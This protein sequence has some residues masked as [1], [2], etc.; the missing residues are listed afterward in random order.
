MMAVIERDL[1][2][3]QSVRSQGVPVPSFGQL[4]LLAG[5]CAAGWWGWTEYVWSRTR[6]QLWNADASFEA[7]NRAIE[8]WV[9]GGAAAIPD[10]VRGLTADDF[11]IRCAAARALGGIGAAA[12]SAAPALR[13]ASKDAHL[14]VRK[15]AIRALAQIAPDDPET[16]DMLMAVARD[17]DPAVREVVGEVIGPLREMALNPL[18]ALLADSQPVIRLEVIQLAHH[19]APDSVEVI[20]ALRRL[21]RD[22]DPS[23]RDY[24]LV[25]LLRNHR[26]SP[27]EILSWIEETNPEVVSQSLVSLAQFGPD[28]V[29]AVPELIRC[30]GRTDLRSTQRYP[31]VIEQALVWLKS[32]GTAAR[33]AIPALVRLLESREGAYNGPL[34]LATL[35]AAGADRDTLVPILVPALADS[36]LCN[37]AGYFLAKVDDDEARRQIPMLIE[38]SHSPDHEISNT[39][40]CAL[41]GLYPVAMTDVSTLTSHLSQESES[42]A[43]WA[44]MALARIGPGAASAVPEIVS[45][46]QRRGSRSHLAPLLIQA[47]GS[48]GPAAAPVTPLLMAVIA[49][50][51]HD[52][53]VRGWALVALARIGSTPPDFVTTL[54]SALGEESPD[55][56]SAALQ[57]LAALHP[58]DA[59]LLPEILRSLS[60]SRAEIRCAAAW[61]IADIVGCRAEVVTALTSHLRDPDARVRWVAAKALGRLGPPAFAA[62][63][64]LRSVRPVKEFP[65]K[66]SYSPPFA[67]LIETDSESRKREQSIAEV[68]LDA[69]RQI[70]P[71]GATAVESP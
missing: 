71:D 55:L 1:P 7:R 60:S 38:K 70:A 34:I 24:A 63:P 39:A 36:H 14:Q 21:E 33:P 6:S 35:A 29:M 56:Q 26:A 18:L 37:S 12:S 25:T 66:M 64:A 67:S 28:A 48:V 41:S 2:M 11:R 15:A 42:I 16:I 8:F 65:E 62:L 27:G 4:L 9:A 59:A 23:V 50:K 51:T 40:F 5:L 54:R 45:Q 31:D 68:I 47:A 10:L 61:T 13:L 3:R 20:S 58:G 17:E 43:I 57:A 49:D 52:A 32:F 44:A 69:I 53:W 19:I 22:P 46:M 30:L